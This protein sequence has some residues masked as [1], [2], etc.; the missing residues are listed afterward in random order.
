MQVFCHDY[1]IRG[2]VRAQLIPRKYLHIDRASNISR[3][4]FGR[5]PWWLLQ[6]DGAIQ[7]NEDQRR[8]SEGKQI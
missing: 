4:T 8:R 6:V 5:H 1:I 2:Y 3:S 7:V